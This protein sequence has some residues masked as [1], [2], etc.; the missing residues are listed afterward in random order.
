ME[1]AGGEPSRDC[2]RQEDLRVGFAERH[3]LG[4]NQA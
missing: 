1:R 3:I 4:R 2:R